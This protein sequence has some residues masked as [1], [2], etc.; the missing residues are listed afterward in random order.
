M[1]IRYLIGPALIWFGVAFGIK[2]WRGKLGREWFGL[3]WLPPDIED[4]IYFHRFLSVFFF[5][6]AV[7]FGVGLIVSA[8]LEFIRHVHS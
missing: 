8:L 7:L 5:G 1:D 4:R 3:M 6:F 2:G